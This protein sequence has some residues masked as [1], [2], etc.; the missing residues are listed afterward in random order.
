MNASHTH[1]SNREIGDYLPGG[2]RIFDVRRGG[3]GVVYCVSNPGLAY[4]FAVKS[5]QHEHLLDPAAV[6][7]F[8]REGEAW[9]MLGR[10]PHIVQAVAVDTIDNQPH[11]FLEYVAGGNLSEEIAHDS[12]PL[13]RALDISLQVCDGMIHIQRTAGLIHR[14]IKPSNILIASD[15]RAQ[16]TDF[17]L[18]SVPGTTVAGALLQGGIPNGVAV[19][20]TVFDIRTADG[21]GE[22]LTDAGSGMGTA[23]YMPPE[24]WRGIAT[25]RSD[26]YAF[27][28]TIYE[29]LCGRLPFV[30]E[31]GEPVFV[32]RAKHATMPPPDIRKFRGDLPAGLITLVNCCLEKH[33]PAQLAREGIR[34]LRIQQKHDLNSCHRPEEKTT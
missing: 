11:L 27:G 34:H 1:P 26:V 7:R 10:H 22:C 14:D 33:Q 13:Q 15:G 28:I 18:V 8:R 3:M 9:I 25:V 6:K 16:I 4:R 21:Q 19:C 20:E 23:A 31:P 12:L 2:Y 32:L 29:M 17:G 5:F 30:L 24:Q